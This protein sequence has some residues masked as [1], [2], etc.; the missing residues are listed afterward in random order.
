MK[1]QRSAAFSTA[2]SGC[3][4]YPCFSTTRAGVGFSFPFSTSLP[5]SSLFPP[6]LH[7]P[8]SFHHSQPAPTSVFSVPPQQTDFLDFS[9]SSSAA[10]HFTRLAALLVTRQSGSSCSW[11]SEILKVSPRVPRPVSKSPEDTGLFTSASGTQRA[12][13]KGMSGA[14]VV[15]LSCH[16]CFCQRGAMWRSLG[17]L[18]QHLAQVGRCFQSLLTLGL[19]SS[20]CFCRTSKKAK[21]KVPLQPRLWAS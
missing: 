15:N 8:Y 16:G 13:Q 7:L 3:S 10:P 14:T 19:S 6:C 9:T 1:P 2:D 5:F 11:Q 20:P 12:Q 4:W 17:D 21:L 18:Q